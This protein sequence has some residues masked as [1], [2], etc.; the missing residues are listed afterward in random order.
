[1][2][3]LFR[4]INTTQAVVES[5]IK[6]NSVTCWSDSEISLFGLPTQTKG[7]NNGQKTGQNVF[8]KCSAVSWR[9]VPGK[10]N[11]AD[12][13]TCKVSPKIC[14]IMLFGGRDLSKHKTEWTERKK[15]TKIQ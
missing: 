4:L 11:L 10:F 9:R 5:E 1:M 6:L 12:I 8:G 7:E 13:P 3:S 15:I 14:K 2:L